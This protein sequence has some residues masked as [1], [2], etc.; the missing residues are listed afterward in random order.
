MTGAVVFLLAIA[1]SIEGLLS[2]SDAPVAWKLGVSAA[3]AVFLGLY[4]MNGVR[5]LRTSAAGAPTTTA[6]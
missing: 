6:G 3:T 5:Y 2:T 1:G 4:L